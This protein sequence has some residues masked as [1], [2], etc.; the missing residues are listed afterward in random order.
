MNSIAVVG[1]IAQLG[2]FP[3]LGACLPDPD[4]ELV[5]RLAALRSTVLRLSVRRGPGERS[6]GT[7]PAVG[8]Q[9]AVGDLGALGDLVIFR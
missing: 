5:M 9:L 3:H 1:T 2:T 8:S 7:Q 6:A 4:E